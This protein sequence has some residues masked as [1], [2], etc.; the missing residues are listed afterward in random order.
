M[1]KEEILQRTSLARL[2][3][4]FATI[5]VAY[6]LG[7]DAKTI[8]RRLEI[9]EVHEKRFEFKKNKDENKFRIIKTV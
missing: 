6:L 4:F 2:I 5:P 1:K 7:V 8:W 9:F 3:N